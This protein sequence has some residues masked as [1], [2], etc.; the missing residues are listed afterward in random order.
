MGK[1]IDIKVK[2]VNIGVCGGDGSGKTNV[3]NGIKEAAEKYNVNVLF[4]RE[5]GGTSISEQIRSVIV[6][7]ENTMMDAM[8]EA[9]LFAAA[10]NQLMKEIVL[11]EIGKRT[12]ISDR[13]I[14]SNYVYQGHVR[15]LGEEKITEINKYA[16]EGMHYD[17]IIYLD[18]D[19]EIA[20]ERITQNNR[21][22]NRLDLETIEFHKKVREGYLL[23]Y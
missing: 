16:M 6:N 2:N 22:T 9:M 21:N 12:I 14:E 5:P 11:P 17:Y 4:V 13:T 3:L 20:Q 15:G 10:R 18:L 8:T 7:K 19:P 23:R 1:I